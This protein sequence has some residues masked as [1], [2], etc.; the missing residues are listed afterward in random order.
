M[1]MS[2]RR[3]IFEI[4]KYH[5]EQN[6]YSE[7]KIASSATIR[8]IAH[9]PPESTACDACGRIEL[10]SAQLE[11]KSLADID[12]LEQREIKI[13]EAGAVGYVDTGISESQWRR[14]RETGW[15]E[16]IGAAPDPLR[17]TKG[18]NPFLWCLGG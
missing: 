7:L 2:G 12:V 9:N 6:L 10:F 17:E 8:A 11:L 1:L 15:I 5:S 13:I 16:P 14:K 3:F 4:R 18:R